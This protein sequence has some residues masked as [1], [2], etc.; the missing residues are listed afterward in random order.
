MLAR[1]CGWKRNLAAKTD[2]KKLIQAEL[3]AVEFSGEK[4][5]PSKAADGFPSR[6]SNS[7]QN[8]EITLKTVVKSLERDYISPVINVSL[9]GS[10]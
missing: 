5:K 7:V 4:T 8:C 2:L 6:P 9:G 3:E 1:K 10:T